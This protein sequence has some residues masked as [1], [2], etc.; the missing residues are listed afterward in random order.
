MAEID[1]QPKRPSLIPLLIGVLLI[2]VI[3]WGVVEWV[4]NEPEA[5]TVAEPLAPIPASEPAPLPVVDIIPVA[6][7]VTTPADYA[8]RS[9]SGRAD[10]AEVISDRGFWIE[11]AGQ[12]LFVVIDEPVPENIDINAGQALELT[13]TVYTKEM[14]DQV[15]GRMEAETRRVAGEQSVFLYVRSAD[16]RIAD[17]PASS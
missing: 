12:R 11:N 15:Q 4:D 17:R 9:V 13:G 2:G 5:V 3:V 10:V 6:V 16:V 14:L 1:L 7:I 8:G